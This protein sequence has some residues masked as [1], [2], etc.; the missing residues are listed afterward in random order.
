MIHCAVVVVAKES[1]ASFVHAHFGDVT[2][3]M[4]QLLRRSTGSDI[5]SIVGTDGIESR[6]IALVVA[7]VVAVG[8]VVVQEM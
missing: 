2:V 5:G 6:A 3:M 8:V 1:V 4:I 7:V